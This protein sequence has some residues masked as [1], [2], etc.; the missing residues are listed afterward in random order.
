[1]V[2]LNNCEIMAYKFISLIDNLKIN[3]LYIIYIFIYSKMVRGLFNFLTVLNVEIATLVL[4]V[5]LVR[6]GGGH[7]W[8]FPLKKRRKLKRLEITL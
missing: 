1:M 2:V 8:P 5:L 4:L 3:I 6:G 7:Q